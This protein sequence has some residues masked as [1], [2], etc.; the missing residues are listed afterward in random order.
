MTDDLQV[1]LKDLERLKLHDKPHLGPTF[2]MAPKPLDALID[3]VHRL[4]VIVSEL[5]QAEKGGP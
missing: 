5:Q 4:T 3:A 2:S 1:L